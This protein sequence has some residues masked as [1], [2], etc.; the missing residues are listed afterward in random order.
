MTETSYEKDIG[1][2]IHIPFCIRK[3][4][5]CDFVSLP[6]METVWEPYVNAVIKEMAIKSG[7]A[8]RRRVMSVF[9]G[10]G[11]PSLLPGEYIQRIMEAAGRY[12]MILPDAEITIEANPGTL[13]REKIRAYRDAGINRLSIGLQAYQDRLLRFLGRVHTAAQ[14]DEAVVMAQDN[15]FEN[16]NADIIFGIPFQS[17]DDWIETVSRVLYHRLP[18]VSCYSLTVEEGTPFGKMKQDGS[19][20]G[21]DEDLERMMYYR[22]IEIFEDAGLMQYEISNLAKPQYRCRHNMNYW[23]RGEYLGFGAAAHSFLNDERW[24]NTADLRL[25]IE[26][27]ENGKT[28]VSECCRISKDEALSES[29]IL[30]LRMTGGID[31]DELSSVYGIDVRGKYGSQLAELAGREL[32]EISG[33]VVRLTKRGK[34]FANQVF[35]EFI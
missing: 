19:W 29:I 35:V 1:I 15:G 11:T 30:G 7:T 32:V 2:Y 18:H 21:T 28:A 4:K 23:L 8:C 6:G 26:S 12:Y 20:P 5:Y 10:G 16:I 13:D 9:I 17:M 31:L 3:C 34:D 33:S 27:V 25:Y 24:A 14:F 22:A